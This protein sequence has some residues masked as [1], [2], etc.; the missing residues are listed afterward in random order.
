MSQSEAMCLTE[1]AALTKFIAG[2]LNPKK[3][4]D[5][6]REAQL[7]F[8]SM[9]GAMTVARMMTDTK[10]ANAFLRCATEKLVGQYC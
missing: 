10:E 9:I 1:A 6:D 4:S 7:L 3:F 8:S 5:V 2:H